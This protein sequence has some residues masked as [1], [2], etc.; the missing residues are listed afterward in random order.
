MFKRKTYDVFHVR[1][2]RDFSSARG[3]TNKGDAISAGSLWA[4]RTFYP[5]DKDAVVYVIERPTNKVVYLHE[6]ECITNG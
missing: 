3:Y 2:P 6:P 1:G 4:A 5:T